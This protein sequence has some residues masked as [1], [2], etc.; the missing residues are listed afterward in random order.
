[1][2]TLRAARPADLPE[3]NK[4]ERLCFSPPWS[5]AMLREEIESPDALVLLA[6]EG[7]EG[8]NVIGFAVF[9]LAGDQA[10]LY[11]IAVSP[12]FRRCGT[13]RKLLQAGGT[14][15]VEKACGEVFLEVRASN[16]PAAA[17]YESA[18]FEPIGRRRSYYTEP[19]EDALL[20]R[21]TIL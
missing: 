18:G 17:L 19:V 21:K 11:Q 3:L 20:Y 1:M 10:E 16:T 6:A 7:N 2:S 13:A 9:H 14:W 15:A 12:A 5:E 4:L 8:E